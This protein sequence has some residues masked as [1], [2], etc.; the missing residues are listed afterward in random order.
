MPSEEDIANAYRDY[1]LHLEG[2]KGFSQKKQKTI[3]VWC[4]RQ[5]YKPIVFISPLRRERKCLNILYLQSTKRGRLLEVGCGDGHR[6]AKIRA[7][8]WEVEGQEV[9]VAAAS[10][11][12]DKLGLPVF[13]G[14]LETLELPASAYDGIIMN[15]VIEHAHDPRSLIK[16]CFRLLKPDGALTMVTPNINSFGHET[17]GPHWYHLDPPRHLRLFSQNNLRQLTEEAGFAKTEMM[18]T[19]ARA[20]SVGRGSIEIKEK[21]KFV[22]GPYPDLR[23][24]LKSIHYQLAATLKC[25][26]DAASGEEC[27]VKAV[28]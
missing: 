8:G 9:N 18:T 14:K 6:L 20:E 2:R 4:I 1:Y 28:K 24:Y 27:V 10:Y 15:H 11:A 5:I 3:P 23:T 12:Q 17:F 13:L 19:A 26:K 22:R 16:E 7:L 25:R 21:G